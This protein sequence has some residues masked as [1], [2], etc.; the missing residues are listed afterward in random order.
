MTLKR[1]DVIT[2]LCGAAAWPVAA[3]A[4]QA[5]RVRRIGMLAAGGLNMRISEAYFR[6]ELAKLGWVEGRGLRIDVRGSG[7]GPGGLAKDAEELVN[8]RTDVIVALT[9]A[10]A[11]AAQRS[12]Q[13]I[14]IVFVGGG[15]PAENNLVGSIA[16]PTNVTGFANNFGSLGGK[17]VQLLKEAVPRVSRVASV[18][19]P[20]FALPGSSVREVIGTAA[21]QLAMTVIDMPVRSPDEIARAINA[22]AAE[23]DGG[24][25]INGAHPAENIRAMLGLALQ[26]RL[27]ALFGAG[28]LVAEGLLMSNGPDLV[29]LARRAAS[30]VHRILRGAKPSDLPVQYPTG[31]PLIVNLKTAKAIGLTIPESFLLLADEVIE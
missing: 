5:E 10:A 20:E 9:G 23:P 31:F 27:P 13:T 6:E 21:A 11:R 4:Q 19:H 1:R 25:V 26:H 7:A 30:Y 28:K 3:R 29:D 14:P 12:T 8:L 16:R 17:W 2:L 24:L 22:F 15:D 18:F